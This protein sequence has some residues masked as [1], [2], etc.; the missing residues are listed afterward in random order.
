[1]FFCSAFSSA[2]FFAFFGSVSWVI[3][4]MF[5]VVW[6]VHFVCAFGFRGLFSLC[7]CLFVVVFCLEVDL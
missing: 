4:S 6:G 5:L 3:V 7:I 2:F 1:V